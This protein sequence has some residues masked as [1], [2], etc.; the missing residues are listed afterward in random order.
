[1][2]Y[3]NI[4]NQIIERAKTRNLIGY[5]ERHHIIP[6]CLG[7]SNSKENI[8]DLTAKEHFICHMLLTNI[9]PKNH[10]LKCA[11]WIMA[12]GFRKSLNNKYKVGS[13]TYDRLKKEFSESIKGKPK[14]KGFMSEKTK[15]KISEANKGVSRSLGT[16][17]SEETK[18]KQSLIKKN[19]KVSEECRNKISS[20]MK[21]KP[22]TEE[23]KV[24]MSLCRLN[25]PTKRHKS[26]IQLT[27]QGI[28]IRE[29][30]KIKEASKFLGK[31]NDT[32]SISSCCQGKLKT[33]MG[34]KWKY[35]NE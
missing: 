4:Y 23:H 35:K 21:G 14:P 29:W 26:V 24:N 5:K 30:N 12:T 33:A 25:K 32:S 6:K 19:H 15:K 10:K 8:V 34:F 31:P 20:S 11:I 13:I 1:M 27:L 22:K 7:G 18:L 28:P 17:R 9:Y 2:N 3:Q 16:K